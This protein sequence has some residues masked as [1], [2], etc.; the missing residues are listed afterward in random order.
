ITFLTITL[1]TCRTIQAQG[2]TYVSN[3]DQTPTGSA[4]IGSDS[5]IAQEFDTLTT[6][7]NTYILNSVQLLL[8]PASGSPSEFSVQIYSSP[9]NDAPQQNLGNL[10]GSADPSAGGLFTYTASGITLSPDMAYFVVVTAATPV[11]QGAYVWSAAN[12]FTRTGN[13]TIDDVYYSSANGSSWTETIRQDV[14]QMAIYATPVPEPETVA[15]FGVGLVALSFWRF[16]QN[17]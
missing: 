14:F 8:N 1:F 16:R 5:W 3:L 12:S 11:A 15:L 10:S 4:E 7:P 9:L 2:T 17:K 13:W 6:D